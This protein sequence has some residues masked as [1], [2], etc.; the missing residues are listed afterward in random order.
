MISQYFTAFTLPQAP[1]FAAFDLSTQL[2]GYRRL[3]CSFVQFDRSADLLQSRRQRF[4]LLL[5]LRESPS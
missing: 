1:R 5:L 2:S 4:N 3:E